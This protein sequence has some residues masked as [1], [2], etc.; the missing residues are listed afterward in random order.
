[1]AQK[2]ITEY[3]KT[4]YFSQS[5]TGPIFYFMQGVKKYTALH[6][7]HVLKYDYDYIL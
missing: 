3:P 7:H 2:C 4:K 6:K 1:M 5:D